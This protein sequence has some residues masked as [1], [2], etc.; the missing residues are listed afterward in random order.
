MSTIEALESMFNPKSIAVL[1]V[2][3]VSKDGDWHGMFAE[4]KTFG[5]PGRL[6]PIN[7][8]ATEINGIKAYPN[9]TALPEKVDLVV[10]SIPAHAV[11]A[12]LLD[13]STSGCKNVHIFT[14]GFKETGEPEGLK[15]QKEIEEIA[16]REN[17]NVVG[18]NCMGFYVPK[19]K[20]S[21]MGNT[22]KKSGPV[23]FISQSGGFIEDFTMYSSKFGIYFSK[24]ISFGNALTLD[25]TDF[26]EYLAQDDDTEI[27][28]MYLE[29]VKNGAK[30]KT[31][32]KEIN[33]EKP[34][35]ILKGGLTESGS[36]AVAT[37]TGSLAGQK[38]MWDA[39]FR[40]TGVVRADSLED[41]A[42]TLQSFLYLKGS[43]GSNVA[44]IGMGGGV[45]VAAAD[46]CSRAGLHLP[47]LSTH[48]Q[49]RLREF[50]E[51]AGNM[52]KNPIDAGAVFDN[53]DELEK[54]F[55]ILNQEPQIDAFIISLHMDWYSGSGKE[56]DV[57]ELADTITSSLPDI[58]KGKPLV[59]SWRS[60]GQGDD[61]KKLVAI[62]ESRLRG[63][64]IPVFEGLD[65][66]AKSL[67]NWVRY[68]ND[69]ER[70]ALRS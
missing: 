15:L 53:V 58:L 44:V 59:V 61:V 21:T 16:R 47:A 49:S 10:F 63:G 14:S 69:K 55:D 12:A 8:K 62:L 19:N 66:A 4:I 32:A 35:I 41:M 34:V 48:A 60:Y 26:L 40:Q 13:C 22:P 2:P 43:A 27:I 9:L 38:K 24:A 30:L 5:Y 51:A 36:R 42:H 1:G 46:A 54:T 3:R 6:Y 57:E 37:H 45:G 39:F 52:T 18:P 17:L 68:Q 23:A 25:S 65:R 11:P 7:P 64:G 67:S 33:S 70:L 31:L 56:N 28:T 50:I 20:L 29:G